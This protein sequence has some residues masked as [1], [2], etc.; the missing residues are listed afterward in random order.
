MSTARKSS[1]LPLRVAVVGAAGKMG[2][3]A[4]AWIEKDPGFELAARIVRG[5][6]LRQALEESRCQVALDLT[7]AGLGAQHGQAM[8]ESGVHPVIGTSG[9]TQ[10]DLE[11]LMVLAK[12]RAIGCLVVPNFCIG[13]AIQQLCARLALDSFGGGADSLPAVGITERH[14][15]EKLDSPSGTALWTAA[16][17]EADGSRPVPIQSDRVP[18]VVAEQT[19]TF[20]SGAEILSIRHSV[21]NREA[22]GPGIMLALSQVMTFTGLEVGLESAFEARLQG[23]TPSGD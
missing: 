16:I 12:E 8:I 17:L 22:F 2:M 7:H 18:G 14:H 19:V 1:G 13:I 9:V 6:D 23:N 11:Q 20:T 5:D 3:L 15:P 4:C 21:E 10:D